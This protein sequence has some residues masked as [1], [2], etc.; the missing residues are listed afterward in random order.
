MTEAG[1]KEMVTHVTGLDVTKIEKLPNNV[2]KIF[3]KGSIQAHDRFN[4]NNSVP[5]GVSVLLEE[6]W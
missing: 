2:F 5:F 6:G 4:V 3:L 1:L